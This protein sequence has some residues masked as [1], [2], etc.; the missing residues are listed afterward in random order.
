VYVNMDLS[1][2]L[3]NLLRS[4]QPAAAIPGSPGQPLPG[5]L[6]KLVQTPLLPEPKPPAGL[7]GLLVPLPGLGESGGDR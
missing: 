5:A 6:G 1:T 3:G 2:T 4:S 7:G